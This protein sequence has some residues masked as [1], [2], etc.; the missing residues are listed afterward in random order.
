ME[1]IPVAH[2]SP[3]AGRTEY[4]EFAPNGSTLVSA[5]EDGTVRLWLW[6]SG[7]LDI[8]IKHHYA[9]KERQ[10]KAAEARRR[11]RAEQGIDSR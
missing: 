7:D 6:K 1:N 4:L 2:L 8:N 3:P 11:E 9:L 10:R 5:H